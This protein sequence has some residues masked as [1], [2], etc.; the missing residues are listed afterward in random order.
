MKSSL[1]AILGFFANTN[2][3]HHLQSLASSGFLCVPTSTQ[4]LTME[5]SLRWKPLA[6]DQACCHLCKSIPV[7]M[8]SL[9]ASLFLPGFGPLD[10]HLSSLPGTT[11]STWSLCFL[12]SL[13]SDMGLSSDAP[14][15][16]CSPCNDLTIH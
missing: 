1:E 6:A 10:V 14:V 9:P 8:E 5:S 3:N 15:H 16:T 12:W 7:H 13:G 4:Q 2:S 11:F